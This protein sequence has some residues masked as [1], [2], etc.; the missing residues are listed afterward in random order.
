MAT[1]QQQY[2]ECILAQLRNGYNDRAARAI[3]RN[4]LLRLAQADAARRGL[5]VP[6]TIDLSDDKHIEVPVDAAEPAI[7]GLISDSMPARSRR[8]NT[9][10]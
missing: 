6:M 1:V 3:C 5:P 8:N 7:P 9:R 4:Q 10:R 2:E